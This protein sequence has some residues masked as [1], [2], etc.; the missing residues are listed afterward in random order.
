MWFYT[1]QL[2]LFYK[3]FNILKM[4]IYLLILIYLFVQNRNVF[5][6]NLYKS[7]VL[8]VFK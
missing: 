4:L 3:I 1:A 7:E 2:Y 6:L 5:K 8:K